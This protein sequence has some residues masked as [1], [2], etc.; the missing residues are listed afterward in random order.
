MGWRIVKYCHHFFWK[1][2]TILSKSVRVDTSHLFNVPAVD[3]GHLVILYRFS[4]PLLLLQFEVTVLNITSWSI[5]DIISYF[6][7]LSCEWDGLKYCCSHSEKS[8]DYW[9]FMTSKTITLRPAPTQF[10]D[11]LPDWLIRKLFRQLAF[12]LIIALGYDVIVMFRLGIFRVRLTLNDLNNLFPSF[13]FSLLPAT[14]FNIISTC[15]KN[16]DKKGTFQLH[17]RKHN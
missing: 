4:S 7:C 3:V 10:P 9:K 14:Y 11:G 1:I 15:H 13:R 12:Q 17:F 2:R 6:P 16:S 8:L 5:L